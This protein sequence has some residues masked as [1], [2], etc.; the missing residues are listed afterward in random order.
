[1]DS[2]TSP[3]PW[4]WII[5]TLARSKQIDLS[6]LLGLFKMAP[7]INDNFGR[8][9][10]EMLSLRVL[11]S[12]SDLANP[13]SSPSSQ[14]IG[15]DPSDCCEDVLRRI[16]SERSSPHL[17]PTG[18]EMSKW[19]LQPFVDHKRSNLPKTALERLKDTILSE[20]IGRFSSLRERSGLTVRHPVD[21]NDDGHLLPDENVVPV[22]RKR[23]VTSKTRVKSF[24][25]QN[26]DVICNELCVQLADVT[27]SVQQSEGKGCS[28]EMG[29]TGPV[30][31][32]DSAASK[33]LVGIDE[34][35]PREKQVLHCDTELNN[36]SD[37]EQ[38]RNRSIEEPKE[39]D[40]EVFDSVKQTNEVVDGNILP[41]N[42]MNVREV[43]EKNPSCFPQSANSQEIS[44]TTKRRNEEERCSLGEKTHEEVTGQK[45]PSGDYTNKSTSSSKGHM[46]N[47]E[48]LPREKQARDSGTV[49]P[50]DE[51]DGEK[52]QDRA[53]EDAEGG[54]K[55]LH[56][57]ITSD[58]DM[59]KL[60]PNS[61]ENVSTVGEAEQCNDVVPS[62]SDGFDDEMTDIDTQKKTFLSSQCTHSQDSLATPDST[63]LNHCEKCKKDGKLLSCSSCSVMIHESC[64]GSDQIY[65]P[66]GIFYCPFCTSSRAISV[67]VEVKKKASSA[68]KDL[69]NF[70]CSITRQESNTQSRG[71]GKG[72]ENHLEQEDGLPSELPS[73]H[74]PPFGGK[75]VDSTNKVAVELNVVT[76]QNSKSPRVDGHNQ[77]VAL[78]V[79]KSRIS[80]HISETAGRSE[81]HGGGTRSENGGVLRAQEKDLP[82]RSRRSQISLS[83]DM[84]EISEESDEN[85]GTSKYFIRVR[86]PNRKSSYPA[87]PRVRR[88]RLPWTKEEENAL[89]KWMRELYDP[90]E[91][92][93]LPYKKIL[94]AGAGVFD[95]SRT[96]TDLKDKWRN[97]CKANAN[98][99]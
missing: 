35:L 81:R 66:K 29:L 53:A 20:N 9:A 8:N 87:I 11:E 27:V 84:D 40:K 63:E 49:A 99:D 85:S 65:D 25:K 31:S 70:I 88:K 14:K 37:E 28:L 79:R 41:E 12:F 32:N 17:K 93:S 36:K 57:S 48:V 98:S 58:K 73:S 89:K 92:K 10:R 33:G 21:D 61:R 19:D 16:L 71:L 2:R 15:L 1:M 3:S 60:E 6:L 55:D 23:K 72:K 68:R 30:E 91:D 83:A 64:L 82:G 52:R 4:N 18:L 75:N 26:C 22:S 46:V 67:Y 59:D 76:R 90:E 5:E 42:I 74:S 45:G 95:P 69:G 34:V 51:L 44:A 43:E 56:G 50:N 54:G 97:I 38:E 80:C 78:A 86:K 62:D 94:E 77:I 47:D 24:K 7:N 96:T 13:V 39:C